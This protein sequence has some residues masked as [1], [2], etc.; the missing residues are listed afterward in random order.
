MNLGSNI[1]EQF[2]EFGIP[3][4]PM[5]HWRFLKC[6][7]QG[8]RGWVQQMAWRD[9]SRTPWCCI[10]RVFAGAGAR[11][12][13]AAR[14]KQAGSR[15]FVGTVQWPDEQGWLASG[16]E[17]RNPLQGLCADRGLH[18]GL[19]DVESVKQ[20]ET[21]NHVC[22]Q[23]VVLTNLKPSQNQVTLLNPVSKLDTNFKIRW[24]DSQNEISKRRS[25][26]GSE[27]RFIQDQRQKLN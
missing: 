8:D 22:L 5:K 14:P 3:L 6:S 21:T 7:G 27:F 13:G 17:G 2:T 4:E 19:R 18:M 23:T 26:S 15:S 10:R 24:S 20:R 12:S 11:P 16:V 9:A 1:L 25:Q